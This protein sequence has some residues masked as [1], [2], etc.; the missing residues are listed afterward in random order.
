MFPVLLSFISRSACVLRHLVVSM[1]KFK[2][3]ELSAF[4]EAIPALEA[5]DLI[6]APDLDR[7][8][9]C[10]S[11]A[12][13]LPNLRELTMDV[14]RPNLDYDAFVIFLC[15]RHPAPAPGKLRWCRI[16]LEDPNPDIKEIARSLGMDE[17]EYIDSG[18]ACELFKVGEY[19]WPPAGPTTAALMKFI[20]D[21]LDL[22]FEF[23]TRVRSS[24]GQMYLS[25]PARPGSPGLAWL[26][27]VWASDFSGPSPSP[28][29]HGGQ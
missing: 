11:A 22:L 13:L 12:D 15:Q 24:I 20:V 16:M 17:Q 4:L 26:E 2:T 5:L 23:K 1:E 29:T 18:I 14:G 3:S 25:G 10:L 19:V 21:G 8:I 9:Y 6:L 28:H 27:A 7:L